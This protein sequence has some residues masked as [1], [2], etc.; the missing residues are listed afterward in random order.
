MATAEEATVIVYGAVT[1]I[2]I[3]GGGLG[4]TVAFAATVPMHAPIRTTL[5]RLCTQAVSALSF[6]LRAFLVAWVWAVRYASRYTYRGNSRPVKRGQ[7]RP[8]VVSRWQA[9]RAYGVRLTLAGQMSA[10]RY[11]ALRGA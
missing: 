3:I 4:I 10:N 5:A 1:V 6:A 8:Q 2:T 9:P 7:H 11:Y